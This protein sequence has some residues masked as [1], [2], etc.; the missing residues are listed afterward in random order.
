MNNDTILKQLNEIFIDVFDDD[1]INIEMGT[2]AEDIDEWDSVMHISLILEIEN[3]F[4]VK[5]SSSEIAALKNVGDL[6][7]L[8]GGKS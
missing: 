2:S 1:E 6:A 5:F 7:N 3:V 4:S 8:V